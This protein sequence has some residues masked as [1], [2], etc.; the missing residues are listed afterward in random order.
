M[1][2]PNCQAI[3]GHS[4][5]FL[6]AKSTLDVT[7]AKRQEKHLSHWERSTSASSAGEGDAAR[8]FAPQIFYAA[9]LTKLRSETRGDVTLNRPNGHLLPEG[10]GVMAGTLHVPSSV[11]AHPT[12]IGRGPEDCLP[13]VR[14]QEKMHAPVVTAIDGLRHFRQR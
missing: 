1:C 3:F 8:R 12:T 6:P 14:S 9:H 13:L 10:E 7:I 5:F 11:A 2:R 4:Q